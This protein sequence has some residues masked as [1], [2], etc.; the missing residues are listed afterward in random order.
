[1]LYEPFAERYIDHQVADHGRAYGQDDAVHEHP[2]TQ[3]LHAAQHEHG[4][5]QNKGAYQNERPPTIFVDPGP[6]E[7]AGE[8]RNHLPD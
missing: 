6:D 1:M 8:S 7:E 4:H 2:L 3:G 5:R